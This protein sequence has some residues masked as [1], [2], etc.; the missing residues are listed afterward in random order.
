MKQ[1]IEYY[2][3]YQNWIYHEKTGMP[4][5]VY[6]VMAEHGTQTA[7]E[8]LA[9]GE[10]AIENNDEIENLPINPKY[11]PNIKKCSNVAFIFIIILVLLAFVLTIMGF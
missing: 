5:N 10:I 1:I 4:A 11:K 6:K 8:M 3:R 2:E 7:L 9:N